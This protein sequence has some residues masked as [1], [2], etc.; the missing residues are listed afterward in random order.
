MTSQCKLLSTFVAI[1]LLVGACGRAG[2]QQSTAQ[3]PQ[4]KTM[5]LTVVAPDIPDGTLVTAAV[6]T[7][8]ATP[9]RI[10][11]VLSESLVDGRLSTSIDAEFERR[12]TLNLAI[13]DGEDT[14]NFGRTEFIIE[15]GELTVTFRP[16]DYADQEVFEVS[17][18]DGPKYNNLFIASW[19]NDVEYQTLFAQSV[20]NQIALFGFLGE[21]R[22]AGIDPDPTRHQELRTNFLESLTAVEEK[23]AGLL[24]NAMA[25]YDDDP[26]VELLHLSRMP[27]GE[28]AERLTALNAIYDDFGEHPEYRLALRSAHE[29]L[30][31]N[32]NS[33]G[34]EIGTV[35][36]DF[37]AESLDGKVFH[38]A[39]VLATNEYVLVEFWASWCG[40]CIAE[41]PHMKTAYKRHRDNGFEIVSF[42]LDHIRED[43]E[44]ASAEN[45]IP[46]PNTSDLLAYTGPVTEMYGVGGIPKNYLVKGETGEIV[47]EDLRQEG[48]D[49]KLDELFERE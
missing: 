20:A 46:W 4:S 8:E 41:I 30:T 16:A 21:A 13:E 29:V 17:Q 39:D 33:S 31:M 36:K 1:A 40:P 49:E 45:E 48:L 44:D 22:E 7:V 42:S 25:A 5:Q 14:R 19:A 35:I 43:W 12:A 3:E 26:V 11:I 18:L 15:P 24:A 34:I 2:D 37:K 10:D 28:P 47:A 32:E 38:L 23:K 9:E 27:F 6:P